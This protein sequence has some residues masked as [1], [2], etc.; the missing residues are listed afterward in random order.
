MTW[1]FIVL[2]VAMVVGPVMMIR[3]SPS[4][5]KRAALRTQASQTGLVVKLASTDS[6][7]AKGGVRAAYYSLPVSDP[8][9]KK[10]TLWSLKKMPYAHD[11]HFSQQWDWEGKDKAEPRHWNLLQQT[12]NELPD[13]ITGLGVNAMGV[14]YLW[15]EKYEQGNEKAVLER[16]KASLTDLASK[17]GYQAKK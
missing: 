2:A 12:L 15:D 7:E 10:L 5:K 4:Q 1:I 3:P 6:S 16:L 9:K 8:S 13:S 11:I 14:F 17:L